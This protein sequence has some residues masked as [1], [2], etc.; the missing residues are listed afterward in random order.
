MK[1]DSK[2]PQGPIDKKWSDYKNHI[3]LVNPANKRNIDVIVVGTGLAGGSAA[4]TLA[5]LGYNVKAFCYQDSPRRAHSIAAQGG[6]NAAKNYQGDG[7]SIYRLF[8]DTVKGGDYRAREANVHRLSEVSANIIDQCVAQGVPLAREYGGL[9]DNRSFGGTQ[10]SRTFYAKG[11]TGQQLLLG[12]YSAMNRQIGRGKIKMYNRHEMLDLVLVDG[13]ARGIIARNLING[14][15]ERHSGHAVVIATGGYGN[16]FFLSTNAM[17][18]NVTAA[19]KAH[20]RGAFFA[21]PCFTQIHP[22]CIPVTGDHQSKLTLMSESLRNDG[23][24][25]VPKKMEDAVAIREGKLKPTQIAEED[26]DYYL[27]RRYPSFGNLVPR[28]VASRAAKERCDA[29]YGVNATGEAVYLDFASAIERYGKEQARIHHLDENDAKLVY[30]LGRD[31]VENKYGNLFQMYEKI[32]DEDPY[33]TPMMIYPAVHYT[34]G[35]VW[36]DYNLMSTIEGCYVI[37]EANFSD[38]GANRLGASALMQGLADGYF[39]LPYTIGDYLADDIRTGAIPTDLPEFDAAEKNVQD[40]IDHLMNNKGS[41]SVDYFHKKLGKI[42][43]DKVGMARNAQGLNEAMDEIAV[44]REEFY[45][46][47]KVSGTADSFNQ[48]LEKALRVADFLEL[49]E[50]FAKDALHREESCGGHF[51]EEHQTED[52]EAQRDDANFAYAAA[53]EY[54]GNPRDAVLHKEDLVYENIKLVTR[55]YK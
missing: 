40:M 1:L 42:M 7:D 16:V 21:N 46:D 5:E 17:G 45:K 3:K 53:W 12:A 50:L 6:I 32:V 15:I 36:V 14:E 10:V 54:K 39:V 44:L 23:R 41:H 31:V 9:L 35:G 22:T 55:S 13:K 28:D 29:G 52:G 27:E 51:R 30:K 18:S 38:H 19:W 43:W 8:Y 37:G 25:W 24:I 34:M 20:K 48:E 33:T 2:I 49:G 4:A 26:R 11:Q 47:V